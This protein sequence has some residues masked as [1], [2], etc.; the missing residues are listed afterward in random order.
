[1][2]ILYITTN[3]ETLTHT[4]ITR[5]V[6]KVRQ[7]G[8]EVD[9]LALRQIAPESKSPHPE[10]DV[11]GCRYVYPVGFGTVLISTVRCLLTRPR[12]LLRTLRIATSDATDSMP[13]KMKLIYQLMAATTLLRWVENR[14]YDHIHAHFASAPT[15]FAMCLHFLTGIPYSFTGHAADVFR[16]ASALKPKIVNSAGVVCISEYNRRYY[17]KLVPE[18]SQTAIVRCG[19]NLENFTRR[20]QKNPAVPL[21]IL[22]VGRCVPKKGF[23]DLL[24]ALAK[25]DEL[26]IAWKGRIA[27]DGPLLTELKKSAAEL[28]I[29]DRLVFLGS[30]SQEK[31]RQL[32]EVAG[33][34]VLPSVPASD[35]DIDGI[36]V[37]LMEAMAVGCP[38]ISTYVS[39]I[40]ELITNG[41]SG[42][43]VQPNDPDGLAL[44][45][46]R[47]SQDPD[48]YQTVSAGGRREVED[49]FDLAKVGEQL[50]VFFSRSGGHS[51]PEH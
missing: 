41:E 46:Q 6:Q 17:K 2:K 42:L 45:I 51:S 10:C 11:S 49:H 28:G 40:P 3:F 21:V 44:A 47:L 13:T 26:G 37:S 39:G 38:V 33:V 43:L 32:L 7:A 35:G 12:R 19:I 31:I 15:T 20:R 14:H 5:E 24:A 25:L 36:P 16:Y 29:A 1:V 50:T 48:L 9:L 27:G 22:A 4:F 30:V 18:L 8:N 23:A 34:F